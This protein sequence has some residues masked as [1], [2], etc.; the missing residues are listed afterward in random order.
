MNSINKVERYRRVLEDSTIDHFQ[1][2]QEE[3]EDDKEMVNRAWRRG[4]A[5]SAS[6]HRVATMDEDDDEDDQ[7][8]HTNALPPLHEQSL[9]AS[10]D[11][12]DDDAEL[13]RY[14]LDFT[15]GTVER[16]RTQL[17]A[18]S[19]LEGSLENGALTLSTIWE[20]FCKARDETRRRRMERM[21]SLNSDVERLSLTITSYCD[22]TDRGMPIVII[23]LLVGVTL[24]RILL[25]NPWRWTLWGFLLFSIRVLWRPTYWYVWGRQVASKRKR[26]LEKYAESNIVTMELVP[27]FAIRK[28]TDSTASAT[29]HHEDIINIRQSRSASSF[30]SDDDVNDYEEGTVSKQ[31][32]I[33]QTT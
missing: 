33:L 6:F 23:V 27:D 20:V 26:T 24:A 5:E 10:F 18:V 13:G 1:D 30:S 19:T 12:D 25:P 4:I 32:E 22:L 8:E 14:N 16:L 31:R 11:L 3:D 17:S 15:E 2:D 29:A 9:S 28:Q 7:A 21:L